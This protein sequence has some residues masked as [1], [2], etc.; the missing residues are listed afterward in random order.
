MS[1][2]STN[3]TLA[4]PLCGDS[5]AALFHGRVWSSPDG[6]VYRCPGCDLTFIHPVM[7]EE[8][9]KEFYKD[10][11][12]HAIA[13]GVV[14]TSD[15]AELHRKGRPAAEKRLE[16]IKKFFQGPSRILEVGASTGAFLELLEGKE[17][18][19]VEPA[20]DHRRYLAR[21]C[22][23]TYSDLCEVPSEEKFDLICMF[24][25]FEHIKTPQPFLQDCARLLDPGGCLI[26][27]VPFIEDP[28]LTL[29][30]CGP[31]KDFYFQL[32]HPYVY[33]ERAL[34][35]VFAKASFKVDE[36]IYY[37]RYGLDNH[38]TWLAKGRAGT[39]PQFAAL[40]GDDEAYKQR[41]EKIGK[42][43]T[44]FCIVRKEK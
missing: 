28:L 14:A 9:E 13:R 17:R 6:K 39:D 35:H 40:F 7:D 34:A 43:D 3:M 38:L 1:Q 37:Q 22:K 31:F 25:V 20:D 44:I 12:K 11:G 16:K 33:S 8:T 26:V 36:F 18:Y 5:R 21:F 19:G 27:E 15:P 30:Q 4:C 10:Y 23:S 2:L 41:M 32:M 24:H 42:T 29:Y